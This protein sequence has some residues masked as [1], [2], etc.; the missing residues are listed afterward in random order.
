MTGKSYIHVYYNRSK[1]AAEQERF[2]TKIDSLDRNYKKL[3]GTKRET[4]SFEK[5][6][7]FERDSDG[8]I[9]TVMQKNAVIENEKKL[10]GYFVIV[11]S[12]RMKAADALRLY[13]SIDESEKLFRA[14]KTFLGNGAFRNSTDEARIRSAYCEEQNIYL[15]GQCSGRG[16][17]WEELHDGACGYKGI[18]K[19]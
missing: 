16:K 12:K 17:Q 15:L 5:Y 2:E 6:F 10:M 14:D 4:D 13:K 9:A 19:D 11:T 3:I 7:R 1:A 8:V 18:G